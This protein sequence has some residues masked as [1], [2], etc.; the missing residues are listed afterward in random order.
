MR[1]SSS[2][3]TSGRKSTPRIRLKTAA[4]APMPS[5]RVATTLKARP[6][7][8]HRERAANF[9]S[10]KNVMTSSF[11][12]VFVRLCEQIAK[13]IETPFPNR[14]AV[15]NPLLCEGKSRGFDAAGAH[16]PHFFGAHQPTLFQNLQVLNDRCQGDLERAGQLGD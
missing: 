15:T 3:L 12:L 5:A 6:L 9:I 2:R 16:P 10:C 1:R 7:L 4:F 8:R 14:A 11:L 13:L